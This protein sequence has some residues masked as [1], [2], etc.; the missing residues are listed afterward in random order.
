MATQ[1][2]ESLSAPFDANKYHD[3]Y[4]EKVLELIEKKAE[5]EIIA[6]PEAPAAQAPVVDLMTALEESLARAKR[7]A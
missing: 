3:D 6:Q 2:V 4:R 7:S 5:G 1:L